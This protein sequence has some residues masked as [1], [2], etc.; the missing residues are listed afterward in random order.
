MYALS[1]IKILMFSKNKKEMDDFIVE[2]QHV[3]EG[4]SVLSNKK[5]CYLVDSI[6]SKDEL[7]AI[8]IE[9]VK[10]FVI[11]QCICP[12]I[13]DLLDKVDAEVFLS[14]NDRKEF[15]KQSN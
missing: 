8:L 14:L 1:S 9:R 7:E 11:F 5:N 6:L 3:F 12:T 2:Y 4:I 10:E 15:Y 13:D